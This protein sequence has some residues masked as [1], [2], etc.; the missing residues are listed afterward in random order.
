MPAYK[1]RNHFKFLGRKCLSLEPSRI[2]TN[3]DVL[4]FWIHDKKSYNLV[5]KEIKLVWSKFFTSTKL[6]E[7]GEV[8]QEAI[9]LH[10]SSFKDSF[11]KLVAAY[12]GLCG[13]PQ[14]RLKPMDPGFPNFQK[15]YREFQLLLS[16]N[17]DIG[18][19]FIHQYLHDSD[20]E[21][22]IKIRMGQ[23]I[24]PHY[25]DICESEKNINIKAGMFFDSE[26]LGKV[27]PLL[28]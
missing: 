19:K 1:S 17:F 27:A 5:F 25:F 28:L 16:K 3:G 14:E 18:S 26:T 12:V 15:R 7:N 9:F 21:Q 6:L 11:D 8:D 24:D 10:R 22:L 2:P 20:R 23:T 13:I 4:R